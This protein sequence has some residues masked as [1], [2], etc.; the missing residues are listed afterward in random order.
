M[1]WVAMV[2]KKI[3]DRWFSEKLNTVERPRGTCARQEWT[4][5]YVRG[6][7]TREISRQAGVSYQTIRRHLLADGVALRGVG[8]PRNSSANA[9]TRYTD[10]RDM[11]MRNL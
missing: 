3:V 10:A 7:S 11:E 4:G 6:A 9:L 5:L 2:G 1:Q 8:R